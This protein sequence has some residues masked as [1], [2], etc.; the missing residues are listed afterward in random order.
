MLAKTSVR[1]DGAPQNNTGLGHRGG[2]DCRI[3]RFLCEPLME[4]I[5]F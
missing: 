5:G 2:D 1:A 3:I 4:K